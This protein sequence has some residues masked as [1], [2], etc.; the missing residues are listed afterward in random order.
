[1]YTYVCTVEDLC[2]LLRNYD[3]QHSVFLMSWIFEEAILFVLTSFNC[4]KR[5]EKIITRRLQHFSSLNLQIT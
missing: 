1:M 4:D 3:L 2:A 5:V